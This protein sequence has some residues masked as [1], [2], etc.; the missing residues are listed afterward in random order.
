MTFLHCVDTLVPAYELLPLIIAKLM[1]KSTPRIPNRGAFR[2]A[3]DRAGLTME[4]FAEQ[5]AAV[6]VRFLHL[7]FAGER[8]SRRLELIVRRF[9]LRHA[10]DVIQHHKS[11]RQ[12]LKK[13]A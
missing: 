12:R 9:Y 6:S 1:E 8:E 3:L 7:W 5:E 2:C 4:E 11:T 10:D 13:A